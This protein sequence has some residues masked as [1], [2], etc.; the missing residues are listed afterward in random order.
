MASAMH[1]LPEFK[2]KKKLSVE[3]K[4][5]VAKNWCLPWPARS[6]TLSRALVL[7]RAPPWGCFLEAGLPDALLLI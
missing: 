6:P 5:K 2:K 7:P 4:A 1:I 3:P